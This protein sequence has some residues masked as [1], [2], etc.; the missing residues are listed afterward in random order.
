MGLMP[1]YAKSQCLIAMPR[2]WIVLEDDQGDGLRAK[3]LFG[4]DHAQLEHAFCDALAALLGINDD[5]TDAQF[6]RKTA[7]AGAA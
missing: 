4:I 5:K 7:L 1:T 6:P 2:R 3:D